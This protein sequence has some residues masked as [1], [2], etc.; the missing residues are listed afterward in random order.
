MTQ[1]SAP[2]PILADEQ[3]GIVT[4][5]LNRPESMNSLSVALKEALLD[6]TRD[7][8]ADRTVRAVV[9]TATGRG[10]CVG[11]DLRE[12]VALLEA[13]DPAPLSTVQVVLAGGVV[14]LAIM[15]ERMLG[16]SVGGRQWAGLALTAGGLMLLGVTLPASHGAQSHFSASSNS[17]EATLGYFA[18]NSA[19]SSRR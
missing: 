4:L 18:A 13:H 17:R 11:Q 3:D 6:A 8:A 7:V 1:N 5:T 10:F 15:A 19:P 14:L 9:L 2:P 12:H 16:V